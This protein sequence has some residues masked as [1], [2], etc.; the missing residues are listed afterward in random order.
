MSASAVVVTS[1]GDQ[2]WC[3][4]GVA[5]FAIGGP[6]AAGAGATVGA[7]TSAVI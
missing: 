1:M 2:R 6:I 3:F 7:V 5:G 4:G